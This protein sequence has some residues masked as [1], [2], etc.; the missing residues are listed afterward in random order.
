MGV[1]THVRSLALSR[2]VRILYRVTQA[3]AVF[4]GWVILDD[5]ET[6]NVEMKHLRDFEYALEQVIIE[7]WKEGGHY[8]DIY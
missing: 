4:W 2:K 7:A 6:K 8:T 5:Q 3:P 1:G